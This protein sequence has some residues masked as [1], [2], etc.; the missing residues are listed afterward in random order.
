MPSI[1]DIE[2][3]ICMNEAGD[4]V[5]DIDADEA[6]PNCLETHGGQALRTVMLMVTMTAPEIA[7]VAVR[8]P[9]DAGQ[10]TVTAVE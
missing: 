7:E 10:T 3:F 4:Y 9:N 8:V 1:H 6:L 5:V 2:V